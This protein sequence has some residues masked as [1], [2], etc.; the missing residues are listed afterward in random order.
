MRDFSALF[1]VVFSFLR[2]HLKHIFAALFSI[3]GPVIL[4]AILGIGFFQG[5][6]LGEFLGLLENGG[7]ALQGT[8]GEATARQFSYEW[9]ASSMLNMLFS[10]VFY[11][12]IALTV[13]V[14]I[15]LQQAQ[16]EE[17]LERITP[18]AV[19]QTMKPY[20]APAFLAGFLFYFISFLGALFCIIPGIFMAVSLSLVMPSIVMDELGAIDA[21]KKS[22][23]LVKENWWFTFGYLF[24]MYLLSSTLV[25][26]LY[27][28]PYLLFV[29]SMVFGVE[30]PQ[31]ILMTLQQNI[32]W[33]LVVVYGLVYFGSLIAQSILQTAIAFQYGN[34][35][36]QKEARGLQQ[37]IDRQ[38]DNPQNT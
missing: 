7:E 11:V 13:L 5:Q 32:Y 24:L 16:S 38:D 22:Y 27:M 20:L 10:Y 21:L 25:S 18:A 28:P 17:Q 3:V 30:D 26:I 4:V 29:F 2:K 35:V 9:V 23:A 19:W 34:L 1:N 33:I 6:I 12:L 15:K 36:E 31:Q 8:Q 14:Y 37:E